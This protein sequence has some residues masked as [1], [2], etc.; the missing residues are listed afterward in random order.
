MPSLLKEK[1]GKRWTISFPHFC[2]LSLS[3][4]FWNFLF[5]SLKEIGHC[6][7]RWMVSIKITSS[8]YCTESMDSTSSILPRTDPWGTPDQIHVD[9]M[10][11]P[12]RGLYRNSR[13]VHRTCI[14]YCTIL[15][16]FPMLTG[17]GCVRVINDR[18]SRLPKLFFRTNI[19][20]WRR[21][22]YLQLI[23]RRRGFIFIRSVFVCLELWALLI[24]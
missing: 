8:A 2:W 18:I 9:Q 22:F 12:H 7:F 24:L 16:C 20:P 3:P 23:F 15:I 6:T 14:Q 19:S 17:A 5:I 10:N 11:H 1:W 13:L 21:T 4:A